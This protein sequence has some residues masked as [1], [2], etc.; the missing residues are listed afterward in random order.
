MAETKITVLC[1]NRSSGLFGVTGE[2]GFS[3]LIEKNNKKFLLDTGQGLTLKNNAD[4]L[5]INLAE[6]DQM[7]LSHGHYDH[8]GGL[9]QVLY[10]PRGVE[11]TAHPDIFDSKYAQMQ[12]E[13][14]VVRRY[15]G[16]KYNREFLEGTFGARFSLK[17]EFSEIAP[18]IYFSGEVPRVTE[19]ELDDDMLKVKRGDELINDPLLD[20]TS[21][22]VETDSGPVI[23]TGCAH[24]GIV[25][26]MTHFQNMTK[27]DKFHA[28]IGGTHLGFR[29]VGEQLEKSM[30]AF[31]DFGLDLIAVSHCTGNEPAA[32]CYSRFRERFAFANAGWTAI[33]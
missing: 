4:A 25:N 30:D 12:T 8:T 29:G 9:P 27:H 32:L 24:A 7:A 10:P 3:A 23:V 14:G 13:Q 31:D 1:E 26:V 5:M 2:H 16:I 20:D 19:F 15:I 18:D 11:I 21:L 28:V 6:I 33:F 22:L 17:K